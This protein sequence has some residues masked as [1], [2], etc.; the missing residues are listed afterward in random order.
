MAEVAAPRAEALLGIK[1]VLEVVEPEESEAETQ[2]R[3]E[4]MLASL[5]SALDG[6]VRAR[7]AEGD[8]LKAVVLQQLESI[9]RLV[10]IV[11][12]SPV[13]RA[14]GHPPAPQGADRRGCWRP[15]SGSMKAAF[16]RRPPC[17]RRAPTWRR[18]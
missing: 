2:A 18:S 4:A 1:G 14:R 3:N 12:A 15:A 6:M 17:W 7:E 16:T 10:A 8:R 13:A 9:E 5:G 11:E